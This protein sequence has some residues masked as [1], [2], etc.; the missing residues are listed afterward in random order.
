MK[1]PAVSLGEIITKE[2]KIKKIC[3]EP[4]PTCLKASLDSSFFKWRSRHF[5]RGSHTEK[6][7]LH[8][9]NLNIFSSR[10][11]G[12][13]STKLGAKHPLMKGILICSNKGPLKWIL[14][15]EMIALQLS[16]RRYVRQSVVVLSISYY[17]FTWSIPNLVQSL[18][19]MSRWSLLIF[20]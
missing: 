14:I 19:S 1:G 8:W 6:A 2:D 18:P 15:K 16:V 20:R 7:K 5:S 9:Y 10:T 11:T 13:I 4:Q 12:P 3:T 17:P